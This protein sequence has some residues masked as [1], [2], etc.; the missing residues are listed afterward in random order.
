MKTREIKIELSKKGIPCIWE[1]GGSYTNTG[2]ST[3]VSDMH[4]VS[5]KPIYICRSG[6]LSCS[7]H[8]L[9]PIRLNDLVITASH[10]RRDFSISICKIVSV[11]KEEKAAELETINSF[12]RGEWDVDLQKYLVDAVEAA[13]AKA[14]CYH[15]RNP[16]F[17]K[18][19]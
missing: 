11:N 10:H 8:A 2:D 12:S 6:H 14:T 1:E 5:K 4:G 15:C 17:T 3:I 18:E 13:K 19:S 16:H 7:Q 9:I